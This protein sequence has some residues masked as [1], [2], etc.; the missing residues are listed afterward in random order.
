MLATTS[1]INR[2]LCWS[3]QKQDDVWYS[4]DLVATD[5][6]NTLQGSD[7]DDFVVLEGGTN[8]VDT[9]LGYDIIDVYDGMN[10]INTGGDDDYVYFDGSS[11]T[12][13]LGDGNDY[14][15]FYGG[16]TA[17]TGGEG[18]DL[19][20]Y[21]YHVASAGAEGKGEGVVYFL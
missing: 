8:T 20:C 1:P 2:L 7:D 21:L 17:I 19:Q 13:D 18:E 9:G 11:T 6:T 16:F 5:G 10:V 3:H 12:I 4:L 15:D 14:I